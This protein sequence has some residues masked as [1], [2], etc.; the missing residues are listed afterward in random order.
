MNKLIALL[1]FL[2]SSVL[3][4]TNIADIM[5]LRSVSFLYSSNSL[6]Y[7]ISNI[8]SWGGR[9]FTPNGNRAVK[10]CGQLRGK[11]DLLNWVNTDVANN[12]CTPCSV[13]R[14]DKS[15]HRA[16]PA[17]GKIFLKD[18]H[19]NIIDPGNNLETNSNGAVIV[20]AN[21][22]VSI[23]HPDFD[24]AGNSLNSCANYKMGQTITPSNVSMGIC[25]GDISLRGVPNKTG[26]DPNYMFR[27]VA[28]DVNDINLNN[29]LRQGG[30]QVLFTPTPAQNCNDQNALSQ[31][32]TVS[33]KM[34]NNQ[35]IIALQA[36]Q[37]SL[38][39]TA[40]LNLVKLQEIITSKFAGAASSKNS[41]IAPLL[42]DNFYHA[43]LNFTIDAT[44]YEITNIS[45]ATYRG[46]AYSKHQRH[47]FYVD[48][49]DHGYLLKSGI[50]SII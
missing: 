15:W 9:Y 17:R 31:H 23:T 42:P 1:S 48:V 25:Y 46:N 8:P 28:Q 13:F 43:E 39:S 14:P 12:M 32:P 44:T 24:M 34:Q 36:C 50:L 30:G 41:L 16:W 40:V 5:A 35:I 21:G 10:I 6:T 47:I 7:Q 18:N 27:F 3:S 49:L 33:V 4:A 45:V 38:N 19:Q 20:D 22:L 2:V 29:L 26:G 37:S 11:N